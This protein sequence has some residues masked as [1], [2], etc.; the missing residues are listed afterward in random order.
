MKKIV[1]TTAFVSDM[2]RICSSEIHEE[3]ARRGVCSNPHTRIAFNTFSSSRSLISFALS[4]PHV[5][6]KKAR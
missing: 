4:F 2:V 6:D 3:T 5:P 1:H